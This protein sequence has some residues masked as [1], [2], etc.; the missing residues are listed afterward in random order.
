MNLQESINNLYEVFQSYTVLGNLRERSCD[1]C[2][3]DEEIKELLS[4]TLK[5]IQPDEIY[6]FM[7]SALTTYGDINDY[8]HFLPRILE[9]TVGYDFLTDFHCYEKLNYANWKS[10]NEN[11]IEAI[12]SFLEL[13]L[14]HHLN[15]LQYIDLIFVIN[16]SIRYLGEEK[17]LN[18]W[19]LHLTEN[20]LYF[21]VDYKLSFSDTIFLDFK[22]TTFDEWISSDFIL[23][24][25]ENLFLKTEDKIEANR[26]SIAYT[27]LENER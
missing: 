16:L 4:K 18:I 15:H 9:L 1:C 2:V 8:K 27:M 19:K 26:I 24:K 6:H 10:W 3:T 13:L 11:E 20:H 12:S 21:F 22:Q 25:L 14:I 5:E 7:L 23:K 17:T